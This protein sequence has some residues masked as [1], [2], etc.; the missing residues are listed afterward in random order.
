M[1]EASKSWSRGLGAVWVAVCVTAIVMPPACSGGGSL[2]PDAVEHLA[3]ANSWI[4]GGGFVN[5]I[6]YNFYLAET[7]P[8]PAFAVRAPAV[9]ALL[10]IPLLA[11]ASVTATAISHTLWSVLVCVASYWLATRFMKP[12]AAA[13]AVLVL[14]ASP[15]WLFVSLVPLTEATGLLA[16]VA[17]VATARGVLLSPR[18][19]LPCA[20]ATW[21]A[22]LT[23]PNFGVLVVVVAVAVVWQVGPRAA[24]R[25]RPLLAYLGGFVAL[26][27]GTHFVVTATTGLAP[28]AGYG[29]ALEHL[30]PMGWWRYGKEYVGVWRFVVEYQEEIFAK[31]L[32]RIVELYQAICIRP[33]H[34]HLGWLVPIGLLH[35]AISW[36]SPKFEQLICT[37]AALAFAL[38]IIANYVAF[39]MLRYPLPLTAAGTLSALMALENWAPRVASR[40]CWGTR[41]RLSA[42]VLLGLLVTLRVATAIAQ[43]PDI[44]KKPSE[45]LKRMSAVCTSFSLDALVAIAKPWP[46]HFMCGNPVIRL[47]IDIGTEG[48]LDRFLDERQPAYLVGKPRHLV[49]DPRLEHIGGRGAFTIYAVRDAIDRPQRWRAPPA[50]ACAGG[51]WACEERGGRMRV[52]SARNDPG[53]APPPP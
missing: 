36:R 50:L 7:A 44:T 38:T 35:S 45:A 25:H 18:E 40:L 13:T 28:Y 20:L 43:T 41:A 9:P 23:R 32:L 8:L 37:L 22:W 10:A 16:F 34:G 48:I 30:H 2:S 24:S 33:I 39:D 49:G 51:E 4:H 31:V 42:Q 15:A 27:L 29:V 21:L 53:E 17:V 46:L 11:G 19:A 26:Y 5:P 14:A 3:I 6:Q 52:I 47:P 12:W 1:G